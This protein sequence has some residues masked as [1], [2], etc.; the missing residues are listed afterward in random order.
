M[1]RG[2]SGGAVML[3]REV[4]VVFRYM[5]IGLDRQEGGEMARRYH[6]S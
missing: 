3:Y 2:V 4:L 6:Q 5:L 1:V